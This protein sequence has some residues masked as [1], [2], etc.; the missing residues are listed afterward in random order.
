MDMQQI[1][2]VGAIAMFLPWVISAI[3]SQNVTPAK[4]ALLAHLAAIV[5][6]II[7]VGAKAN[8]VFTDMTT[9]M[10]LADIGTVV[11]VSKIAYDRIWNGSPEMT[12]FQT[13]RTQLTAGA[14]LAEQVAT[15]PD[16]SATVV[17]IEALIVRWNTTVDVTG[18]QAIVKAM[19]D[20]RDKYIGTSDIVALI[21]SS[22]VPKVLTA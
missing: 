9:A 6:G 14:S 21:D 5:V 4:R 15:K 18:K 1:E 3:A 12:A 22:P 13:A 19:N 16:Y 20:L 10:A 2:Q 8:W 7:Y 11:A 17:V